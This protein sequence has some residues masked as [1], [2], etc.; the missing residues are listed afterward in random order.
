MALLVPSLDIKTIKHSSLEWSQLLDIGPRVI[1][2]R[3]YSVVSG[4]GLDFGYG[5]SRGADIQ[6][7]WEIGD[8]S[9]YVLSGLERWCLSS[10]SSSSSSLTDCLLSYSYEQAPTLNHLEYSISIS[11]LMKWCGNK[12]KPTT[13]VIMQ[14]FTKMGGT[15]AVMCEVVLLLFYFFVCVCVLLF[16]V[17]MSNVSCLVSVR[18]LP[19]AAILLRG[20]CVTSHVS[21]WGG[22]G[23]FNNTR[24]K[25]REME[26]Q[27]DIE[28]YRGRSREKSSSQAL[29]VEQ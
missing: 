8:P 6:S 20:L 3:M 18:C 7:H 19:H 26:T 27:W 13:C 29:Q 12:K 5:T 17:C 9:L 10:S 21:V 4:A 15:L 16:C 11:M 1:W 25:H 22:G 24:G 2:W 14:L 28:R 23:I